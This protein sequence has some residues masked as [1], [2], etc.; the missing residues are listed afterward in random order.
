VTPFPVMQEECAMTSKCCFPQSHDALITAE[1]MPEETVKVIAAPSSKAYSDCAE[2][3]VTVKCHEHVPHMSY[4]NMSCDTPPPWG[5]RAA[6]PPCPHTGRSCLAHRTPNSRHICYGTCHIT[7]D[8][9][10]RTQRINVLRI[11]SIVCRIRPY[12]PPVHV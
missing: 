9:G 3:K 5:C 12:M 6:R 10:K 1:H 2:T 7:K 8:V 11:N 4:N